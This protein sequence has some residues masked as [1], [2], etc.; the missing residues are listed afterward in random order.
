[1]KSIFHIASNQAK[2]LYIF[3]PPCSITT[4]T[5]NYYYYCYY[6]YR[7]FLGCFSG[8]TCRPP[9]AKTILW[10]YVHRLTQKVCHYKPAGVQQRVA[11]S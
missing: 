8:H 1:M 7:Y 11:A 5:T 6:Y 2:Q 9:T 3:E 10:Q 4:T